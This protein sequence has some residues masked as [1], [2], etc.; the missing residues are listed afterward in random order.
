MKPQMKMLRWHGAWLL[1]LGE[2]EERREDEDCTA[3]SMVSSSVVAKR[4]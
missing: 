1:A 3:L 4:R 2:R